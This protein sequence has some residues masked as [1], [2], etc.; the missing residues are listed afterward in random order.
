MDAESQAVLK[1]TSRLHLQMEEALGA[2]KGTI[3]R[4][5]RRP[6]VC[7]DNMEVPEIMDTTYAIVY[8]I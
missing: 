1:T 7:F 3:S 2:Q 8:C 4:V 6:K 5:V